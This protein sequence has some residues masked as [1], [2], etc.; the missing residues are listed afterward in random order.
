[1]KKTIYLLISL[2]LVLSMVLVACKPAAETPV[3]EVVEEVEEVAE[4][5]VEE[6][7]TEEVVEE[8][9]TAEPTEEVVEVVVPEFASVPTANGETTTRKGAWVDEVALSIVDSESAITQIEADAI[10]IYPVGMATVEQFNA[11]KDAGLEN[12]FGGGLYYELT[13][14]PVGDPTF[15][16]TGKL[17]PFSSAKVREAMNWIIDRDYINQEVYGGIAT[18]K[19][20]PQHTSLPD[21]SRYIEVFREIEAYY[22]YDF[23]KGAAIIE[24]ELTAMGAEKVDGKWTYEGEPVVVIFLI[25]SDSD[26]TRVPIGNYIANQLELLGLTVDRQLKTSAEASP[27]WLGDPNLGV[28]HLYTGACSATA[29]SRNSGDDVQFFEAPQSVYGST[30]LWQAYTLDPEYSQMV[31]DLAYANY[32]NMDERAEIFAQVQKE[33]F[34]YSY[35]VWLVDGKSFAT[36]DN[37]VSVSYDLMAGVDGSSFWPYTLRFVDQEGGVVRMGTNAILNDP[38]NGVAGSNWAFDQT[39]VR[40]IGDYGVMLNPFTGVAMPQRIEKAEL[41]VQTG[42][43]VTQTYDWLTL[44]FEDSIAVPE[45]A[46]VDWNVETQTFVTAAEKWP[47]G[48]TS[49]RKS[50]VYYPAD[51]FE[52]MTWHDGSPFDMADFVMGMIMTFERG[53]EGSAIYDE[54]YAATLESSLSA[55]KGW[56]IVSED[57]LI[58]ET[59]S[60]YWDLDAENIVDT[61][62]PEYGYGNASWHL[63]ALSNKAEAAGQLTYSQDKAE[64]L[65]VEWLSWASGPSMEILAGNLA[66][67][68][69][70]PVIPFEATLGAYITPEEAAARYANLQSFYE[71]YGHFYANCGP[72]ILAEVYPVEQTLVL[73]NNPNYIDYADKWSLF[74]EP[75][76]AVVELDGSGRVTAG[77]TATFDVYV[78]TEAGEAYPPEEVSFVKYLVFNADDSLLEVAEA[79]LVEAGYYTIELSEETTGKLEAGA[80][81]IEVAVAVIPV[82]LPAFAS[83]D[84]VTE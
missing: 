28:W 70:E 80:C 49:L 53:R 37:D 2:V 6:E 1:M 60:D 46:W 38:I 56:R 47:E 78:S 67:L 15:S 5:V 20:T 11:I 31:D 21:Y 81:K 16:E 68:V 59:Y 54:S 44:T 62:W 27:L 17:N 77:T 29:I 33:R 64:T 58:V 74:A 32:A 13:I 51:F 23:E 50:T 63:I 35:R 52:Q 26:G 61:L 55:F 30:G 12:S 40:A 79:S 71:T 18:P 19:F 34:Q 22:A 25:R 66:E 65:G 76:N 75:K 83:L 43:P 72:Y 45:D 24:E 69:A 9:P 48:A 57:P 82:A 14:N 3:E 84:F 36:W 7:P 39:W 8:E 41:V 73:K 10:D 42:L 4:E